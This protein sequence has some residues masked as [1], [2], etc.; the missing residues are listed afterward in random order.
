[1]GEQRTTRLLAWTVSSIVITMLVLSAVSWARVLD[2]RGLR[3]SSE[4]LRSMT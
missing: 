1:M 3:M 4:G 2:L